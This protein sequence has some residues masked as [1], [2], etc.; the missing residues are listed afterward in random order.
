MCGAES[1][2]NEVIIEGAMLSVCE[3][4][5]GFGNAVEVKQPVISSLEETRASRNISVEEPVSFVVEGA[6]KLVKEAREK[7]GLKQEQLAKMVGE[8]ESVIH[9]IETSVMKPDIKSARK[10]EKILDIKIIEEYSESDSKM[11]FNLN[12]KD[13]TIGD[14]INLKK[15]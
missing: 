14:L 6:G 2:L 4:C 7:R 13:V 9:K 12:D 1:K 11:T 8:K 15:R 3:K 10:F 5:S